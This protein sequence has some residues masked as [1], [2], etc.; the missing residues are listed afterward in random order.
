MW[1]SSQSCDGRAGPHAA[2]HGE[3]FCSPEV[4]PEGAHGILLPQGQGYKFLEAVGPQRGCPDARLQGAQRWGGPGFNK[5][6]GVAAGKVP[7]T[8]G[9]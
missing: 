9:S 5:G 2:H 1:L 8:G 6:G 4:G 3:P 7:S